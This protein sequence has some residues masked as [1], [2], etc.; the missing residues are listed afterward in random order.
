[1]PEDT[2]SSAPA[3]MPFTSIDDVNK[4]IN[5]LD[6]ARQ[7]RSKAE[8]QR[9]KDVKF[10]SRANGIPEGFKLEEFIT[11]STSEEIRSSAGR[12]AEIIRRATPDL[13]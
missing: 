10:Y 9:A 1:M 5:D 11:G 12:L 13:E 6:A 8:E 2:T 3:S 4:F 7:R